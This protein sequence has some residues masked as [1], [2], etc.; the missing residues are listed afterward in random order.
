MTVDFDVVIIGGTSH[1]REAAAIAAREGARVALVE[2]PGTMAAYWRRQLTVQVLAEAGR[3]VQ[4]ATLSQVQPG[5]PM[6]VTADFAWPVL[7][8]RVQQLADITTTPLSLDQLGL[9]GVDVVLGEGQ[10]APK[11]RLALTTTDRPLR[12]RGYVLSPATAVTVPAIPG[13]SQTPYLTPETLLTLEQLPEALVIL[14]RS[15]EAIALAQSLAWLGSAVTLVSRGRQ[16]VPTEDPDI[17]TFVESLL[18][19]AGVKLRLGAS[20]ESINHAGQFHIQLADGESL[21]TPQLLLATGGHPLV[22]DLNL[23]RVGIHTDKTGISV[24]D[25]CATSRPRIF[26]CGPALGS[27]WAETMDS[28]D[29]A[30][31]L[32]NALYLPHRQLRSLRRTASLATIPEFAR[33]GMTAHQAHHWYGADITRLQVP[34]SQV[35]RFQLSGDIIGF[36]RWVVHRDG[37]ILGAQICGAGASDLIQTVAWLIQQDIPLHRLSQ[38]PHLPATATEMLVRTA[39]SWQDH[40]WQRGTWRRDWAE[41]W[42]N[43]RRSRRHP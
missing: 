29:V 6:A 18:L 8:Q 1:G 23:S 25:R 21:T 16:L 26:A 12:A 38:L 33:I 39:E 2:P 43:W 40:R 5:E 35:G 24:D 19:A 15:T 27:Y 36:C 10:F 11:P 3:Q 17:S 41:N 28:Q 42:F 7:R 22:A 13:L 9:R 37:R 30:I 34:F 20:L 31:A 4:R 32:R 14:G